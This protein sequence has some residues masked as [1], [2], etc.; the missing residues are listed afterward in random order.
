MPG[1]YCRLIDACQKVEGAEKI[2]A[3]DVQRNTSDGN[4]Y[5]GKKF[6][7]CSVGAIYQKMIWFILPT[8]KLKFYSSLASLLMTGMERVE[9][10][11]RQPRQNAIHSLCQWMYQ[12]ENGLQKASRRA[13]KTNLQ[14]P[15]AARKTRPSS[16]LSHWRAL[17]FTGN[18]FI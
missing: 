8:W 6:L 17:N 9:G 15:E 12:P 11:C 16:G 4:N 7:V 3:I 14:H 5:T 2:W 10:R 13:F 1:T 18:Y